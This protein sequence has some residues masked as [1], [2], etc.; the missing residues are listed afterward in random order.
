MLLCLIAKLVE[1]ERYSA[2]S[3]FCLW[4]IYGKTSPTEIY[5]WGDSA[6]QRIKARGVGIHCLNANGTPLTA[7]EHGKLHP[8]TLEGQI[9][10]LEPPPNLPVE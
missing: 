5:R 4:G 10:T 2:L 8:Q 9:I 7:E 3:E 6:Y 1:D